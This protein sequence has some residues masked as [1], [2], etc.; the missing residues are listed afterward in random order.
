[1]GDS[2]LLD[3]LDSLPKRRTAQGGMVTVFLSIVLLILL[4]GDVRNFLSGVPTTEFAIDEKIGENIQINLDMTVNIRDAAGDRE[5]VNESDVA[6]DGTFFAISK[7]HPVDGKAR[8]L[9]I[10]DTVYEG[11]KRKVVRDEQRSS[12]YNPRGPS[13]FPKTHPRVTNGPA[14][15]IYGSM[16]VKRVTGN[17]HITAAGYGYWSMLQTPPNQLNFTHVIHELS[18]GPFFPRI[19]EPLDSNVEIAKE[20]S[21]SYQYYLSIVPTRFIS[22]SGRH[23][24]TNQYSVTDYVRTLGPKDRTIPGIFFKYDVEPLAL[25]IRARSTTWISFLVRLAGV[26]GGLWVCTGMAIRVIHR[27]KG[28]LLRMSSASLKSTSGS[29]PVWPTKEQHQPYEAGYS[30]AWDASG[31]GGGSS[32]AVRTGYTGIL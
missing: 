17:L 19:T 5:I 4:W 6:K 9:D 7:A 28:L 10:G 31:Y 26:I 30:G 15:R 32:A 25:T 16:I 20:H 18:F 29:E 24:D 27:A 22:T 8:S 3:K 21:M 12:K 23:I 13:G 14:C 2:S 11:K 1:M